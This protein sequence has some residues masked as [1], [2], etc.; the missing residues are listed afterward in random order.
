MSKFFHFFISW[1]SALFIWLLAWSIPFFIYFSHENTGY[2][3]DGLGN[4][5]AVMFLSISWLAAGIWLFGIYLIKKYFPLRKKLHI[6]LWVLL[7][8][9]RVLAFP[10]LLFTLILF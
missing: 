10:M 8:I 7:P 5:F 4:I 1:K 3:A 9:V 6:L 2:Y